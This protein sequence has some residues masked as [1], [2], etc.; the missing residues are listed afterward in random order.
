[1]RFSRLPGFGT[2]SPLLRRYLHRG[3]TP[4]TC[5]WPGR[6]RG[7][8]LSPQRVWK[9]LR[10]YANKAGIGKRR[11]YPHR[12]RHTHTYKTEAVRGRAKLHTLRD[13]LGH[14]N[15]ATMGRY[16]HADQS[17]LE[18]VAA[19]L[20]SVLGRWVGGEPFSNSDGGARA[21]RAAPPPSEWSR[22]WRRYRGHGRSRGRLAGRG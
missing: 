11:V 2:Q 8:H 14:P 7:K 19:A 10:H 16:L 20:P 4:N 12:A 22:D 9:F 17:E 5:G 15:L 18:A 13:L 1:M 3:V 6:K 21:S